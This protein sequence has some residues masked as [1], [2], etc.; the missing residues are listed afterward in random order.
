M[1]LREN[2]MQPNHPKFMAQM[3]HQVACMQF[4][5]SRNSTPYNCPLIPR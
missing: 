3:R 4:A 2:G 1:M 5:F